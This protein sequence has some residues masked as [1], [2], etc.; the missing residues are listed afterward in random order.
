MVSSGAMQQPNLNPVSA[1]AVEN[2]RNQVVLIHTGA[3]ATP[4][5]LSRLGAPQVLSDTA[6]SADQA[7]LLGLSI[8]ISVSDS[9]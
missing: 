5:L 3:A 4:M 7:L 2:H 6:Y 1:T 9:G 8:W